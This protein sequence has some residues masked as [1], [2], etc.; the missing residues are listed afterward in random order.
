MRI[1]IL[2][3]YVC[4]KV[5]IAR[6]T[7]RGPENRSVLTFPYLY[8]SSGECVGRWPKSVEEI[9]PFFGYDV[10]TKPPRLTWLGGHF[11]VSRCRAASSVR[12]LCWFD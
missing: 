5:G 6:S 11:F 4:V 7:C 3:G 2:T 8:T 12:S 1:C 10:W 9:S